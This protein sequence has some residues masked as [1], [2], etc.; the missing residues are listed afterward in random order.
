M[1]IDFTTGFEHL[2][3]APYLSDLA[4]CDFEVFTC[5]KKELCGC[6]H[7]N[8]EELIQHVN[9]I[10][11]TFKADWYDHIFQSWVQRRQKNLYHGSCYFEKL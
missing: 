3:H 6:H 2:Y 1:D 8:Q 11:R 5:V 9:S 10:V 4:P 7:G